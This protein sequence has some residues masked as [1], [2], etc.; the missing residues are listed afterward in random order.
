[1]K[2][3]LLSIFALMLMTTLGARADIDIDATNFPDEKFRAYLLSQPYGTDGKLTAEEIAG[4]KNIRVVYKD[5]QSLKGIEHFTALTTLT[6]SFNRIAKLDVSQNTALEE[7]NCCSNWL[8]ALDVTKNTALTE[9]WC[10]DNRITSLDLSKNTAL[11]QLA[12]SENQLTTLDLSQNTALTFVNCSNNQL[13]ALDLSKN[14][15]LDELNCFGNKITSLDMTQNTALKEIDCSNNVLSALDVT[16][17]AALEYLSCEHN[18]LATL[19]VTKNTALETL[20]CDDNQLTALDLSKDA[21]LK[22]LNISQNKIVGEAM[23]ALTASLP[24]V[25]ESKLYAIYNEQEQN[26][27]TTTQV[28]AANAKGWT[29]YAYDGDDWQEYAGSDPT[30]VQNVKAAAGAQAAGAKKYFKGGKLIIEDNGSEFDAAGAQT[31]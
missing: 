6:C 1:M 31:K 5:I 9:L 22:E 25:S 13:T 21:V 27:M 15:A 16:K 24:T 29:A 2:K 20:M 4:V 23:D 18:Q 17:C 8:T 14:T 10:Y 12:C 3:K 28:T 11:T 7:L 19:D 26:E 30:A